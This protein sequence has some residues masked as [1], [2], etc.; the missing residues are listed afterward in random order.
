[1]DIAPKLS[2]T[3]EEWKFPQKFQVPELQHVSDSIV[4]VLL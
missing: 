3:K 4:L 2:G 1:M